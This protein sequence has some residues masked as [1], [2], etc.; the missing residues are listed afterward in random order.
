MRAL[1]EAAHQARRKRVPGVEDEHIFRARP[2][3]SDNAGKPREAAAPL[4]LA[5]LV[6]VVHEHEGELHRVGRE[7]AAPEESLHTRR[8]ESGGQKACG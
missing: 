3:G 5:H 6:D 8:R 4:I 7:G 1:I 2:L